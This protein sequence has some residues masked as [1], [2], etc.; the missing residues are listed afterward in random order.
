M[1]ARG[2]GAGIGTAV[3]AKLERVL[4]TLVD[5]GSN[6]VNYLRSALIGTF[7]GIVPASAP[8]PPGCSP[9][10]RPRTA[11]ASR[12]SSAPATCPA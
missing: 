11:R 6:I 2:A 9:M 8:A 10:P 1:R 3:R 4:P 12:R 5:I 7:V